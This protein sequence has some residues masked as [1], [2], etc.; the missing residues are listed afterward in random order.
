MMHTLSSITSK[1]I[2]DPNTVRPPTDSSET[3]NEI[4]TP[5]RSLTHPTF[6]GR[7]SARARIFREASRS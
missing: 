2:L 6:S 7:I 5:E 1:L 4:N 3:E